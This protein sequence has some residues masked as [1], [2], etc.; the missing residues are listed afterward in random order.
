[1]IRIAVPAL[2]ALL[3]VA[4]LV[5]VASYNR[6]RPPFS[7][8]TLTERELLL[9]AYSPQDEERELKLSIAFEQRNDPLDAR[10]WLTEDRLRALGFSLDVPPGAPEAEDRY[11][12]QP[13]RLGWIVLE[14][15][16][17]AWKEIARRRELERSNATVWR[18]WLESSRLVPVDAALDAEALQRRYPTGYL[19]VRGV[20]GVVFAPP[21][22]G[23]PLVY[24]QIRALTPS[25]VTVPRH[26]R[27]LLA[28]LTRSARRH[29]DDG[30]TVVEP[31]YEVDLAVGSLGLPYVAGVRRTDAD[32]R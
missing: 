5:G 18:G 28:D 22:Q 6:S 13:P 15:A 17:P 30:T 7:A 29:P 9:T 10:N 32:A 1:M 14:Y 26:L 4:V 20:I 24:G 19:I 25:Q 3:V 31:R 2:T 21:E 23:G 11:G 12:K 16:G 8:V 27:P